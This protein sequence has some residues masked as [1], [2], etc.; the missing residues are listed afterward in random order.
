MDAKKFKRL[1]EKLGLDPEQLARELGCDRATVT[2]YE[3]G[4]MNITTR[5]EKAIRNIAELT[6]LRV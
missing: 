6:R 3:N 5:T 1:R 4:T 2:R